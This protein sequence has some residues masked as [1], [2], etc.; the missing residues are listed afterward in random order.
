MPIFTE[1]L[2]L[3]LGVPKNVSVNSLF[4]VKVYSLSLISCPVKVASH[5][6]VEDLGSQTGLAHNV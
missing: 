2:K 3:L 1:Q 5:S 6:T 4:N